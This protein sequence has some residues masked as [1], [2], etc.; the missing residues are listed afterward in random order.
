MRVKV[1]KY[2]VQDLSPADGPRD[3]ISVLYTDL[4][5]YI[6]SQDY[7]V[8][9]RR[10][11]DD[12][13]FVKGFENDPKVYLLRNEFTIIRWKNVILPKKLFEI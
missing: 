10:N 9:V 2:V 12:S 4:C 6:R 5:S 8:E 1:K 7:K 13:Y 11:D 3:S